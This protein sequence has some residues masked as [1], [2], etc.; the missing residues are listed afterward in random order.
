M[1]TIYANATEGD[2][3]V[4]QQEA[5][6]AIRAGAQARYLKRAGRYGWDTKLIEVTTDN[7]LI[8][9]L[10]ENGV[11]QDYSVTTFCC[12]FGLHS[13]PVTKQD[14]LDEVGAFIVWSH[15]GK[16]NPTKVHKTQRIAEMEA[17]RLTKLE[18]KVFCVMK[19]VAMAKP[20]V[21]VELI[22]K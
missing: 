14:E 10:F 16:S 1:K 2:S 4:A 19:C 21:G 11:G 18:H 6:A 9:V 3:N 15:H 20:L 13:L 12:T 22:R 17:S 7:R 8:R 5:I